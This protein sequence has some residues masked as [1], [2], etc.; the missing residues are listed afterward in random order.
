MP[1]PNNIRDLEH[2]K[3]VDS[4]TR[5]NASAIE[6]VAAQKN[7]VTENITNLSMLPSEVVNISSVASKR[8][9]IISQKAIRWAYSLDG[10]TWNKVGLGGYVEISFAPSLFLKNFDLSKANSVTIEVIG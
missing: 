7:L 4:P 8:V 9:R 6:V 3:F 1:K 10:S 5:P 2:L